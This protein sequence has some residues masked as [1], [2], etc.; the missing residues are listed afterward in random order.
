MN[1]PWTDIGRVEGE[2]QS[3]HNDLHRK[4]ESY[5]ITTINGKLDSLE[6]TVREISTT[7]DGIFYRLQELGEKINMI[8]GNP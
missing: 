2:I 5:E 4:A 1:A 8:G 7:V 3:I 6:R